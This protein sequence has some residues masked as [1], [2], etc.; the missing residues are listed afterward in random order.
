MD[1]ISRGCFISI[2]GIEGCGKSTQCTLLKEWLEERGV[3]VLLAREP[4]GTEISEKIR[5]ILLDPVNTDM[6]H[7]TELLLYLASR[8]QI[9]QEL[10]LPA[11]KSG[12]IVLVDRYSDSTL[13][14]Q[15][16]GRGL[17]MEEIIP[18]NSFASRELVPD[19]T[20]LLDLDPEMGLDRKRRETET[21]GDRLEM[22]NLA[23]HRKVREGFLDIARR[24][25]GRVVIVD[26]N[27]AIRE[28][29]ADIRKIVSE[30]LSL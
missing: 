9:V 23:F 14:Y 4:G 8:S 28:I 27:R 2:E 19:L 10:L 15:G 16:Y 6:D 21:E 7:R 11:R 25:P 12:K 3:D 30:K 22:E 29:Q 17:R 26:S 1:G 18:I 20:I 13:A 24:D 5:G